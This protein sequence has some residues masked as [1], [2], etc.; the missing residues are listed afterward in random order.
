MVPDF[1]SPHKG[2]G[3]EGEAVPE[4]PKQTELDVREAVTGLT[5]L[6]LP[7]DSAALHGERNFGSPSRR[8]EP[9]AD[10]QLPSALWVIL[11][12]ILTLILYLKNCREI[13]GTQILG[14]RNREGGGACND[15]H[16][17]LG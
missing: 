16:R 10:N 12:K 13:W 3:S 7:Q 6:P 9:R 8:Q 15:Q 4:R 11:Q 14:I 1:S 2:G 17:D 5:A